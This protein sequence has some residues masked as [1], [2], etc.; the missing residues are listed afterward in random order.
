M[1]DDYV[2]TIS[3]LQEC[4]SDKELAI[5]LDTNDFK[6]ANKTILDCL[7]EKLKNTEEI[8]DFCDQLEKISTSQELKAIIHEIQKGN[9][10]AHWQYIY[11]HT[12]VHSY[13]QYSSCDL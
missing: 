5:I 6:L 3:K 1:P 13:I 12:N 10:Y 11:V 2:Q 7:I 4:F 8:L 9:F